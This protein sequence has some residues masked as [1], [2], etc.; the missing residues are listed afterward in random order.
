M[1]QPVLRPAGSCSGGDLNESCDSG[2]CACFNHIQRNSATAQPELPEHIER[3]EQ[4]VPE[5]AITDPFEGSDVVLNP[6]NLPLVDMSHPDGAAAQ[7]Y[8][9]KFGVTPE[10]ASATIR[11]QAV[12][13]AAVNNLAN[14][15]GSIA[16]ELTRADTATKAFSWNRLVYGRQLRWALAATDGRTRRTAPNTGAHPMCR[17]EAMV[18][19][20]PSIRAGRVR[21]W[22][23][24]V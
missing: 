1:S 23:W 19:D 22:W 14:W 9:A 13:I 15:S 24:A 10:K 18:A 6:D 7:G 4:P 3:L 8:A 21:L 5:D 12:A 17:C 16:D 11:W 2:R 20:A